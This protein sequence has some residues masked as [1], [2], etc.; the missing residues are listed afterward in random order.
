MNRPHR[1]GAIGG[2][3][4]AATNLRARGR[5]PAALAGDREQGVGPAAAPDATAPGS[6][7]SALD[8]QL[9]PQPTARFCE[10]STYS[11]ID[12]A[13]LWDCSGPRACDLTGSDCLVCDQ[14][15]QSCPG[16]RCSFDAFVSTVEDTTDGCAL[17][18]GTALAWRGA[19][20][21]VMPTA[22]VCS[23]SIWF[24]GAMSLPGTYRQQEDGTYVGRFPLFGGT[25]TGIQA[26]TGALR[27]IFSCPACQ[28]VLGP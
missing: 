25:C 2:F 8:C 26:P 3:T 13:C 27:I 12:G 24:E 10:G 20:V 7:T 28:F 11:C 15:P 21:Q 14:Q 6:C 17:Y 5:C 23:Y 18:P 1:A 16:Q 22:R 19:R 9:P 4:E